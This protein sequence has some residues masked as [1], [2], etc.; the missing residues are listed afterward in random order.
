MSA[1][2]DK[3]NPLLFVGLHLAQGLGEGATKNT[4]VSLLQ[5]F[6]HIHDF[7]G[8]KGAGVDAGGEGEVD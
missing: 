3:Q 5:F 2:M 4:A 7:H 6:A 1:P 8:W